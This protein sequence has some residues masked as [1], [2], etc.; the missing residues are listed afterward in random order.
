[1][2]KKTNSKE[3]FEEKISKKMSKIVD[4]FDNPFYCKLVLWDDDILIGF[5]SIFSTDGDERKDLSSWYATMYVNEEFRGG[6]ILW[7]NLKK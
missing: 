2:D 1:M 6:L 3:Y 7:T 5:L 4:N